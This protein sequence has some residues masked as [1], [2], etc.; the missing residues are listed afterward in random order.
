[1]IGLHVADTSSTLGYRRHVE[2]YVQTVETCRILPVE[3]PHVDGVDEL[4]G[5]R[6]D[7]VCCFTD[8]AGLRRRRSFVHSFIPRTQAQRIIRTSFPPQ[9]ADVYGAQVCRSNACIVTLRHQR[10]QHSSAFCGENEMKT[11]RKTE[12]TKQIV[13]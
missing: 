13:I 11:E 8:T 10:R 9:N 4:L 5:R 12:F 1:M 2:R 6:P 7:T 3:C